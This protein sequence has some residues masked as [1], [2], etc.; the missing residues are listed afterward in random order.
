MCSCDKEL[1]DVDIWLI[2]SQALVE[3]AISRTFEYQELKIDS[4]GSESNVPI[5]PKES[6]QIANFGFQSSKK[7]GS[8]ISNGTSSSSKVLARAVAR[9][10]DLAKQRVEQ[11]KEKVKLEAKI[12][13]K[14]AELDAQLAIKEA[15]PEAVRKVERGIASK[16][17]G[18]R[19]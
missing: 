8:K 7:S 12:A 3:E 13:P 4:V 11:L 14:K 10:V 5:A 18:R 16:A 19:R 9:E 6:K 2:E 15:E 1:Q 17:R